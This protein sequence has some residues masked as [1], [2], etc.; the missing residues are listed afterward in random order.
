MAK[1]FRKRPIV[2]ALVVRKKP[3]KLTRKAVAS[4][5]KR[6]VQRNEETKTVVSQH[7][8]ATAKHDTCY[9][10]TLLNN[11]NQGTSSTTRIGDHIF[12]KGFSIKL[13][14]HSV[15]ATSKSCLFRLMIVR[16][17]KDTA[18]TEAQVFDSTTPT[19]YMVV[20]HTNTDYCKVLLDKLIQFD[21]KSSDGSPATHVRKFW[22]G[23]NSKH[24]FDS[25]DSDLGKYYNYHLVLTP[26]L[27]NGVAGTTDACVYGLDIKTYYKDA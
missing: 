22:V 26:Y 12:L 14:G 13:F 3:T 2:K 7:G 6:V 20:R 4:I 19:T 5:A 17:K 11:V 18:L 23:I 21:T 24:I 16:C 10:S 9:T 15:A 8:Y 25:A 27:S 1:T